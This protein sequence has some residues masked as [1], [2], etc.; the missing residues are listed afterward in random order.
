MAPL[1]VLLKWYPER[2]LAWLIVIVISVLGSHR[3]YIKKQANNPKMKAIFNGYLMSLF[4]LTVLSR[5]GISDY[6]IDIIPLH[7][8]FEFVSTMRWEILIDDILNI[9]L[10]VP[11]GVFVKIRNHDCDVSKIV[12]CGLGVSLTIEILQL[13]LRRGYFEVDDLI[14][15]TLG[16]FVGYLLY[17]IKYKND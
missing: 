6:Y 10:F 4:F 11:F 2:L 5:L 12:I 3:Y 17:L 14:N 13:L 9:V 16:V 8:Y 1:F 15:N 7:S